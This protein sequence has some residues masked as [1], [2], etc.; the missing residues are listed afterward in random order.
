[1]LRKAAAGALTLLCRLATASA[2]EATEGGSGDTPFKPKQP[3]GYFF[4]GGRSATAAGKTTASGQMFV[5]YRAPARVTQPYPIVL[6]HGT[7]QTG[8]NF[9]GTPDGRPGWADRFAAK[10]FTV[11]VVDQV[12]RGRGRRSG[13]LRTLCPPARRGS[14]DGVH[15][16]G[17]R[18][19]LPAGEAAQPVAGRPGGAR[20]R[21]LRPVSTCPGALY[22][23]RAEE[24]G[25]GRS[26]P[27]RPSGEDRPRDPADAFAGRRLRLGGFRSAPRPREGACRRRAQRADLLRHPLQGGAD[28]YERVG[29]ARARPYGITRVRCISSPPSAARP[30]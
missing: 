15:R 14:G 22:R 26:G 24:R 29:E 17:T 16:A 20:Q 13:D 1:M 25:T 6:V 21:R 30:I 8:I 3:A 4:V 28:W 7:A 12:G 10:G 11:Y 18:P 5:E 19:A 27:D 9:L 2:S 23:Q